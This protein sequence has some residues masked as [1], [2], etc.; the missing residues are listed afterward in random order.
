MTRL[1]LINIDERRSRVRWLGSRTADRFGGVTV[2]GLAL[3]GLWLDPR[4][5]QDADPFE[6]HRLGR[7]QT[8]LSNLSLAAARSSHRHCSTVRR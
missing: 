8:K 7:D 2:M 5:P 3:K 4:L 1:T 6:D